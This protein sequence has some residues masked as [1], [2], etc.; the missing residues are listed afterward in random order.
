MRLLILVTFLQAAPGGFD[1]PYVAPLAAFIA[2]PVKVLVDIVRGAWV[3]IPAGLVPLVGVVCAF[4][5]SSVVLLAAK[6]HF[7]GSV[8]AQCAIAAVMA[9]VGAMA[10]SAVQNKVNEIRGSS[11]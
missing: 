11:N 8:W 1:L 4:A 10:A 5:F 3:G 7:D 6:I 9:Q 2:L